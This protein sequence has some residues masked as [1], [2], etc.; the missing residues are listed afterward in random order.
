[1]CPSDISLNTTH[2]IIARSVTQN[3]VLTFLKFSYV[4][5]HH[6]LRCF[7]TVKERPA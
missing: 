6:L 1:M 4:F 3:R 2:I 5:G 7:D